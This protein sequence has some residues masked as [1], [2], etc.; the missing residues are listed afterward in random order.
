MQACAGDYC[1][2]PGINLFGDPGHEAKIIPKQSIFYLTQMGII[3]KGYK[4]GTTI[5]QTLCSFNS[6]YIMMV[7][8]WRMCDDETR[9][10]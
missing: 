8:F 9:K 1:N 10:D 5:T 6:F 2:D 4:I 7:Q 3:H